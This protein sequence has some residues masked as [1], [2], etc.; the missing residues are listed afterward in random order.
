[1]PVLK[2][3]NFVIFSLLFVVN[4]LLS[5]QI[6]N[7]TAMK[8]L[9]GFSELANLMDFDLL[10]V[11]FGQSDASAYARLGLEIASTGKL[12]NENLFAL[13][14]WPPGQMIFNSLIFRLFG[15]D[16]WGLV[17]VLIMIFSWTFTVWLIYFNKLVAS[18]LNVSI[19]LYT[20]FFLFIH[21]N[22]W[23]LGIG[24]FFT[25]TTSFLFFIGFIHMFFLK[26]KYNNCN[27]ILIGG[28]SGLLI[29]V[30]VLF[31]AQ[32][33]YIIIATLIYLVISIIVEMRKAQTKT[34]LEFSIGF[35]SISTII[36]LPYL[37]YSNTVL[38]K[39]SINI[40]DSSY[41]WTIPWMQLENSNWLKQSGGGWVCDLN[42]E[43]C[44][45]PKLE[46]F[47]YPEMTFHVIKKFPIEYMSN[48][49]HYFSKAWFARD[50]L[51]AVGDWN[52]K[53]GGTLLI[54]VF[55]TVFVIDILNR[56]RARSL[57]VL[58]MIL[59]LVVPLFIVQI[60][61]RYLSAIKLL[62]LLYALFVFS[63]KWFKRELIK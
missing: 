24:I 30:A 11:G 21:Y 47:S 39:D 40:V 1:M 34:S 15:I 56:N 26:L 51:A 23:I 41:R 16:N 7:T 62:I 59:S 28:V 19:L 22:N 31:R 53:I 54:L 33:I 27:N 8:K 6:L 48:R 58:A 14:M 36:L 4:I 50:Q 9:W 49:V 29:C 43:L 44:S 46:S 57:F 52:F 55:L 45:Q 61:V 3:K 25:E 32:F 37:I 18:N 10:L 38:K 2:A 13:N 42:M 35:L 60:E 5:V 12:A 20:I 17:Y 63:E